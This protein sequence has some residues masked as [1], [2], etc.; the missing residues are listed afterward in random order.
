MD[1]FLF[2]CK[3]LSFNLR[4]T[5]LC[6]NVKLASCDGIFFRIIF[7]YLFTTMPSPFTMHEHTLKPTEIDSKYKRINKITF[8]RYLQN[9]HVI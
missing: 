6:R 4:E 8:L 9:F 3:P 7:V 1:V 5:Y 2:C